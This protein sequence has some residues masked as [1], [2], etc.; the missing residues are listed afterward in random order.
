MDTP[1]GGYPRVRA[2]QAQL[3][4]VIRFQVGLLRY[5]RLGAASRSV[6][7]ADSDKQIVQFGARL[8][9]SVSAAGTP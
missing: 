9:A 1:D 2:D 7:V 4:G 5:R 3:L 6:G 8:A